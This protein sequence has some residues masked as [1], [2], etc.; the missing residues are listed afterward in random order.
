MPFF[1][2]R[3]TL[4]KRLFEDLDETPMIFGPLLKPTM[5]ADPQYCPHVR[6]LPVKKTQDPAKTTQL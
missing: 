5:G 3:R 1:Q 4:S 6:L 2:L